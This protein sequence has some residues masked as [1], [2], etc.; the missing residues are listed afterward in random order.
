MPLSEELLDFWFGTTLTEPSSIPAERLKFW[1]GGGEQVDDLIRQRFSAQLIAA[2]RGEWQGLQGSPRG[3]LALIL[4]LDQFPRNI[5]R[6]T[7]QAFAYDGKA[8]QQCLAGLSNQEDL[9]LPA[10]ARAFFYLP[11]E[12]SE[13]LEHQERS[14]ELF[15]ALRGQAPAEQSASFESFL[16]YAIRHHDIIVRFGRFPHR[17]RML[18]R[19][20]TLEE[21]EF[22]KQPGSS[23]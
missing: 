23:F 16:D 3:R 17:N 1:F 21:I 10:V 12:H 18:A 9:L 7:D 13:E 5:Y 6:G 14:V 11:L 2:D 8:L 15:H 22:L 4:L 19:E 20:S